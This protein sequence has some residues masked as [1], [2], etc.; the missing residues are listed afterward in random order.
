MLLSACSRRLRGAKAKFFLTHSQR[1]SFTPFVQD[2]LNTWRRDGTIEM[3]IGGSLLCVIG[4]DQLLQYQ[5]ESNRKRIMQ[6]LQDE[7][8][9]RSAEEMVEL[10]SWLNRPALFECRVRKLAQNL[11][12]TKC[13]KEVAIGDIVQ[14][15]EEK[16]GPGDMYNLCRTV[17]RNGRTISAGWFPTMYLEKI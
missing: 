12:G 7:A 11:D 17:D 9:T 2:K 4:V 10:E 14:V 5:Q 16:V 15:L 1:R 6:E 3:F 13:L 8:G